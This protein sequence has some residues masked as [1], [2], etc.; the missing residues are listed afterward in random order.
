LRADSWLSG[1]AA[2]VH[3][4]G[5]GNDPAPLAKSRVLRRKNRACLAQI[6]MVGGNSLFDGVHAGGDRSR[7]RRETE[8]RMS[9]ITMFVMVAAALAAISLF[10]GVASMAHGGAE[11]QRDSHWMM[12]RRVGWQAL[13]LMFILFA[14]LA[15]EA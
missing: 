14:L 3:G 12:F 6:N 7:S 15:A 1:L 13:A 9:L 4:P 5:S 10:N 11:D 2:S 8:A